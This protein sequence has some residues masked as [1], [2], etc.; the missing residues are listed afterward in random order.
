[1]RTFVARLDRP[2]S[3]VSRWG[4]NLGAV[5]IVVTAAI[6]TMNCIARYVFNWPL[7]FVDE[8]SCYMLVALVYL[9]LGAT[10]R[11]GKHVYVDM[12]V[13]KLPAP[14]QRA[15]SIATMGLGILPLAIMSWYSWKSFW[16]IYT[17]NIVSLTPLQTP[18]WVP[19]LMVAVGL[20]IFLL[21]MIAVVGT[22]LT[23]AGP[24]R[25]G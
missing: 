9:G 22:K 18:L 14:L 4:G 11:A 3:R 23:S 25:N 2:L 1:M 6:I 17:G 5:L 8:Y 16:S 10:L 13:G 21:D 15:M 12:F 7:M 24:S 20:T 19:Y